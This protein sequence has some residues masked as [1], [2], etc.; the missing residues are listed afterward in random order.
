MRLHL[1][2]I[3][4]GAVVALIGFQSSARAEW[5]D[6]CA[7]TSVKRVIAEAKSETVKKETPQERTDRLT[8][9]YDSNK[10]GIV[11][12]D[13]YYENHFKRTMVNDK[14]KDGKIT[15]SEEI[16]LEGRCS[17]QHLD[18]DKDGVFSEEE[19]RE[20]YETSFR[21]LDKN[22]NGQLELSEL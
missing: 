16:P 7:P 8:R 6:W 13:E 10:D 9:T 4:C 12:R 11:E 1:L 2:N 15:Y 3:A 21:S 19:I 17:Y 22:N 20:H 5:V 14:N 18:L